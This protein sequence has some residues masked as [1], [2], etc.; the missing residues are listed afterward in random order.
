[1]ELRKDTALIVVDMQNAFCHEDG[2][3]SKT[4]LDWTA[5][6]RAIG[7]VVRLV[8][9]AHACGMPVFFTRYVVNEDYSDAGLFPELFP[10]LAELRGMVTGTW[11][12]EIVDELTPQG[13]DRVIDKPRQS[14]FY[15]TD[16]EEQLR[17]LGVD[18]VIVCG[19]VTNMCV[20]S[21]VRDAYCRDIRVVIPSDA[22]ASVA[23]E[24]H[25]GALRTFVYGFG[26]VVTVDELEAAMSRG[27]AVSG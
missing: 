17:E 18:S 13:G 22:T 15:R 12:A 24:M 25:E 1:M 14:A 3:L 19:V 20:E 7:P 8:D 21:T 5:H 16:L 4:G 27:V 9:A 6:N 11:D 2:S 26:P 23:R 10:A